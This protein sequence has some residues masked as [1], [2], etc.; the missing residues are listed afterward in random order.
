MCTEA[1][2]LGD[3]IVRGHG[4][5][6]GSEVQCACG[7]GY[8]PEPQAEAD[9]DSPPR[10]PAAPRQHAASPHRISE[11]YIMTIIFTQLVNPVESHGYR[12]LVN[13]PI[14]Y[15]PQSLHLVVSGWVIAWRR[16]DPGWP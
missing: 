14:H 6:S 5:L 4:G 10:L 11:L 12:P 7:R 1:R 9:R 16:P 3:H 2:K 13:Y 15:H 8:E